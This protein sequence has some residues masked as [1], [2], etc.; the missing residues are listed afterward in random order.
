MSYRFVVVAALFLVSAIT[1]SSQ[2][3]RPVLA[4]GNTVLIAEY[5]CAADQLAR[6]DAAIKEITGPVLNKYVSAGKLI[7]WG[8]LGVYVG[9]HANRT[10]YVWASDPVALMQ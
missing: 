1:L 2:T 4:P 5:D 7:S 9:G 8:Y 6:V 10:I 3:P